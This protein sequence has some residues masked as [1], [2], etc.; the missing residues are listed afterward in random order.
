MSQSES[1]IS[2]LTASIQILR[3]IYGSRFAITSITTVTLHKGDFMKQQQQTI[4]KLSL[5]LCVALLTACGTTKSTDDSTGSTEQSSRVEVSAGKPLASCNRA[6]NTNLDFS[7]S[8]VLDSSGQVSEQYIKLKFN[9]VAS[10]MAASGYYLRFYKWRVSAGVSQLDPTPLDFNSYNLSSNT[11]TSSAASA[12]YTNQIST[13][14]GFYINLR[15]DASNT[16][17]VLKAV[18]YKSDGTIAA[19]QNILIPQFMANPV[20]YQLNSD[21][22]ARSITLQNLH[23]LKNA[24]T[25]GWTST[26]FQQAFDQYCF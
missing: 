3:V 2:I 15:D 4:L 26:Q 11:A 22:S 23:P 9:Y 19:Q 21:G 6:S 18:V 14:S 13:S 17:Q 25:T 10:T 1:T 5:V 20:D 16:Y 8:T 7:V 24:A 12:Y